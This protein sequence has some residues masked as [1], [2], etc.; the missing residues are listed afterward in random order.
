MIKSENKNLGSE[1]G[2]E[3]VTLLKEPAEC[4]LNN[5]SLGIVGKGLQRNRIKSEPGPVRVRVVRNGHEVL[6]FTTPE[7]IT[8]S[9]HRT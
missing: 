4:Y 2:I 9:P 5:T 6:S 1:D 3:L 7:A 8:E